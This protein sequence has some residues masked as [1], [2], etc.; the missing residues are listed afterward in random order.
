LKKLLLALLFV[1]SNAWATDFQ[2]IWWDSTKSGMGIIIGQ[3]GAN[4]FV[5]WFTYG[6]NG[7]PTWY[8][9]T[10]PV[11]V[12]GANSLEG[13]SQ[14]STSGTIQQYSGTPPTS[15]N[16]NAV[17]AT[18][19]GV[20]TITFT[21]AIAAGFSYSLNGVQGSM[22]LSRFNFATVPPDGSYGGG[23]TLNASG[24]S[25]SNDNGLVSDFV[26][27]DISTN[28]SSISIAE[29]YSSGLTCNYSGTYA[30]VGTKYYGSGSFNCSNSYSGSWATND[31]SIHDIFMTGQ[32][33]MSYTSGE[34]CSVVG[35]LGMYNSTGNPAA[36]K[37][38][39]RKSAL[40]R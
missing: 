3:Q 4:L 33:G 21:S 29:T 2:D 5:S 17:S 15:Y 20:G 10:A 37:S 24:C 1:C 19:V 32:F 40:V 11:V 8:V 18:N 36:A 30:Q 16:P 25:N 6:A 35:E 7:S 31:L 38:A 23:L 28:G 14:Q 12:T 9:F 39:Q 13:L 34:T 22:N 26:T 27:W